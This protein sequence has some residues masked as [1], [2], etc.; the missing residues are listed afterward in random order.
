MLRQ[1]WERV[2][3]KDFRSLVDYIAPLS[4]GRLDS[5][6][7]FAVSTGFGCDE[8]AAQFE[9]DHDEYNSILTK[10]LADRLAEAFAEYLHHFVRTQVWK[11]EQ[12]DQFRPED[13]ISERYRGIRPAFGYPACPDHLPKRKFFQMLDVT[14][15]TG[16]Q[17]TESLVMWPAA[18]ISG[19]Y[20]AHP[21]ARYFTIDRLTRDQVE[22]YA[23]RCDME[24]AMIER[25]LASNLAY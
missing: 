19:L 21:E 14:E 17:L 13:L 15:K 25:W 9:K 16:I 8:L 20:F 24:L 23:R 12:P 2:G 1:Q 22:D 7:A 4:S 18:S 5:L 10:A 3:Q 6:G 11:Y